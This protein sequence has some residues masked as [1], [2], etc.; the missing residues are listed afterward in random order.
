MERNFDIPYVFNVLYEHVTKRKNYIFIKNI[1]LKNK[2]PPIFL[3]VND[4]N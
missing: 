3:Q 4:F 2:L 1:L